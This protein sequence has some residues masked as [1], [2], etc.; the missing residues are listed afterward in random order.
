[1]KVFHG[2]FAHTPSFGELEILQ[3][4][5]VG[6]DN[7]GIIAFIEKN[8]DIV[9]SQYNISENNILNYYD[10]DNTK[11]FVPGFIDLHIHSA[12]YSYAGTGTN[13]TLM[14]WLKMY[15]YPSENKLKNNPKYA[16]HLYNKLIHR[17]ISNG[18]TTTQFFGTIDIDSCLIL[19]NIIH[20]YGIRG[21]IG[22]V[23]QDQYSPDY[24]CE[25]THQSIDNTEIFINKILSLNSDLIY[26]V[27]TP[28]FIPNCSLKLL[29]GLS[30]LFNKYRE[31]VHIQSHITESLD[32]IEFVNK[33][34]DNKSDTTIF[35]K[36][37]LLNDKCVMVHAV[38][39]N[40]KDLKILSSKG[41][42]IV[43]C[44]LSN[45]FF[46]HGSLDVYKLVNKYGLNI[47]LGT[48]IAGGYSY[49]MLQCMRQTVIT[50]RI[51]HKNNYNKFI[52][53]K[54]ALYLATYGG[55]KCLKLHHKIGLFKVG[56]C[57]DAVL[58]DIDNNIDIF[59]YDK[60]IYNIFE[61]IMNLSDDRNIK[62]VW[63]KGNK[64]NVSSTISKL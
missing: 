13:I 61:K 39:C 14:K 47:G 54:H 49:S 28:R 58:L 18:T 59:E 44:P 34:Y 29:K 37:N 32:E 11:I 46:A 53:Y 10:K 42:G 31:T 3:N 5:Y 62:G 45:A 30:K 12:Q 2:N 7:D 43:H 57:F 4:V 55:A 27:I 17:L 48:D 64:I 50:N 51:I 40:D 38:H 8:K 15:A 60:N 1:M 16:Y 26:P 56:M 20:K 63:V 22:K 35:N 52:N 19:A 21:F 33:L 41:V 9:C 24:Y 25:N 36:Y 6:I 23:C